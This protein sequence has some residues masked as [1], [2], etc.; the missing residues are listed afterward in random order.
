MFWIIFD[1][2]KECFEDKLVLCKGMTKTFIKKY[3]K[4]A[5]QN[6]QMKS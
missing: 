6:G 5:F 3:L 2:E 4:A 1:K